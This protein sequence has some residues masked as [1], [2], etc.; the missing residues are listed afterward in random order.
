VANC[1]RCGQPQSE[2][3]YNGA[4]YGLCGEYVAPGGNREA[5]MVELRWVK[6]SHGWPP[7]LE[8]RERDPVSGR[9]SEWVRV[10]LVSATDE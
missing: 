5:V 6:Q 2:H 9:W 3:H 8:Y 7:V 10:P 1:A 4:C